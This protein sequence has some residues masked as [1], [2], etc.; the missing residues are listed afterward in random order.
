MVA[1]RGNEG[2]GMLWDW[3]IYTQK[4]KSCPDSHGRK[5]TWH[6]WPPQVTP[7]SILVTAAQSSASAKGVVRSALAIATLRLS[8]HGANVQG[9]EDSCQPQW[10]G[11]LRRPCWFFEHKHVD[12]TPLH[13]RPK[14]IVSVPNVFKIAR[15]MCVL[16]APCRASTALTRVQT[17]L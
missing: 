14:Q 16:T 9:P 17:C 4:N 10:L 1:F 3:V 12:H 11:T 13:C 5:S 7:G 15:N 2:D 8:K 6:G